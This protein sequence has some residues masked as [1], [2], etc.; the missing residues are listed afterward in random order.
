MK[1]LLSLLIVGGMIGFYPLFSQMGMMGEGMHGGGMM[2]DHMMQQGG[3]MQRKMCK[4]MDGMHGMMRRMEIHY[5]KKLF[6]KAENMVPEN[7][8]LK[9]KTL[10]MELIEKAL[11]QKT[12]IKIEKMKLSELLKSPDFNPSDAKKLLKSITDKEYKLKEYY[13]NA[14]SNLRKTIGKDNFK[15]LFSMPMMMQQ[16]QGGGMMKGMMAPQKDK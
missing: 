16:Q 3:M 1:K 5:I 4:M 7:L 14:L 15:K 2:Q 9:V 11:R 6:Y 13:I 8:K 10:K 12:E